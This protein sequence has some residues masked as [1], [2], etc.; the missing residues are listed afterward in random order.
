MLLGI[1]KDV[2]ARHGV[3]DLNHLFDCSDEDA[4]RELISY[5]GVGPTSAFCV[6]SICLQRETFAV[7]THI[8]RGHWIVRLETG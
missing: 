3:W 6:M 1:I 8:Y 5:K 2:H 7:D 4:M